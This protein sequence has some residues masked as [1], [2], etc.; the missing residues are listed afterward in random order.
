MYL[1]KGPCAFN[2]LN[3][4]IGV[5]GIFYYFGFIREYTACITQLLKETRTLGNIDNKYKLKATINLN[6]CK[7]I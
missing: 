3:Q 6:D 7:I 1:K 4:T 5:N 2:T